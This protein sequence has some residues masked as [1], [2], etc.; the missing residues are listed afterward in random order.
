MSVSWVLY[1]FR[2]PR[3][4]HRAFIWHPFLVARLCDRQA[5]FHVMLILYQLWYLF[6]TGSLMYCYRMLEYYVLIIF[7]HIFCVSYLY[8]LMHILCVC[9]FCHFNERPLSTVSYALFLCL[10]WKVSN[11]L[12]KRLK[13]YSESWICRSSGCANILR[14]MSKDK[15][16]RK[17]TYF[18]WCRKLPW[19]PSDRNVLSSPSLSH[20]PAG[21]LSAI[22]QTHTISCYQ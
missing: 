10:W 13:L 6:Y 22:I 21:H 11:D 7:V 4:V 3:S 15:A 5:L 8:V 2:V 9:I 16:T 14:N 18:I 12:N 1:E 20:S 17:K 19:T